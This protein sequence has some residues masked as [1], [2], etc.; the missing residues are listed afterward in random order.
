MYKHLVTISIRYLFR[1]LQSYHS[2]I[3]GMIGSFFFQKKAASLEK[4]GASGSNGN[5][6]GNNKILITFSKILVM[7]TEAC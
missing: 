3:F 6:N 7:Y 4:G 2:L 5:K 1:I